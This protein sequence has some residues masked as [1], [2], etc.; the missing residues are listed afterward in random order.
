MRKPGIY[1]G[2]VIV[3]VSFLTLIVAFGVRLS[4]S[5][6]FV[7]LIDE[8]GWLRA[9]T[10]LIFSVSMVVFAAV[11][12]P[13]GYTLDRWGARRTFGL[14]ALLLALG[15]V[16]SSLTHR[17]WQLTLAYGL[18]AGT[19]ITILG[20]GPQ[21]ALIS[22]WFRR[23]RGLAI[24]IAFAGTGLGT[25][26]FTP[27]AER[28]ISLFGWRV[29]YLALAGLAFATLPGILLFLRLNPQDMGLSPDGATQ[30]DHPDGKPAL[31][32]NWKISAA[33]RTPVFW[34]LILASLGAIGPLRML[35][36]HQIAALVD[37]G[38]NRLYAASVIG[39]EGAVTA[40]AFMLL[41]GISDRIGRRLTYAFGSACLISAIFILS[42]L[43]TAEQPAWLFLY[44]LLLGL[45]EGSRSSLVTAVA[46]DLFP[47]EAI[48]TING[49]VGAAFGAGAAFFPWLAGWLHDLRHSYTLPLEIA[50]AAVLLSTL[51]LW[52][53]QAMPTPVPGKEKLAAQDRFPPE[54]F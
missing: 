27:G 16:L 19:G 26:T 23:R 38:F 39:L 14:G 36:V 53:T 3:A 43:S 7:A 30:I 32:A 50:A 49:A 54:A 24:G 12:T 35:T 10:A 2:W 13:A 33:I 42:Q 9:D 44:V 37:A 8:F 28:L 45:G 29:A 22:R 31:Q 51:F 6:F 5:V 46:S 18:V 41:G 21:A 40:L 11:S 15:L 52:M 17:L 47:G 48:G 34:L 25:L 4:F 1:Y 20:L